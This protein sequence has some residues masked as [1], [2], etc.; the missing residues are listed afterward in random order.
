[1]RHTTM[2]PFKLS[3]YAFAMKSDILLYG[4]FNQIVLYSCHGRKR[5]FS[6]KL[7]AHFPLVIEAAASRLKLNSLLS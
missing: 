7:H 2:A 3:K 4:G 1:M 6:V 5:E